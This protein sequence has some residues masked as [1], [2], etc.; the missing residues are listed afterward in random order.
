MKQSA[1]GRA[2]VSMM[3]AAVVRKAISRADRVLKATTAGFGMK[4]RR[5][6][7]GC[8]RARRRSSTTEERQRTR[9]SK[10]HIA[11]SQEALHAPGA[12]HTCA[13]ILGVVEQAVSCAVCRWASGANVWI[14]PRGRITHGMQASST[15]AHQRSLWTVPHHTH[16]VARCAC[17]R[18]GERVGII[19]EFLRRAHSLVGGREFAHGF[20]IG[21]GSAIAN[22][23]HELGRSN[24][25]F[26]PPFQHGI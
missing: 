8:G 2:L 7:G 21:Q 18:E 14:W 4:R 19:Q 16:V 6:V 10:S 12:R 17:R 11:V 23:H 25:N 1:N 22:Q 3:A 13:A 20:A 5:Y 26:F 24:G 9:R 15:C